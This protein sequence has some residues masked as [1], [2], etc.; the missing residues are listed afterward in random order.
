[1]R[2]TEPVYFEFE[3]CPWFIKLQYSVK[4]PEI[5]EYKDVSHTLPVQWVEKG[6]PKDG[7]VYFNPIFICPGKEDQ[8]CGIKAYNLY[9][10]PGE[11]LFLCRSCHD[12]TYRSAQ[13]TTEREARKFFK[14]VGLL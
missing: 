2:Q 3:S 6:R 12:L 11:D 1:M 4:H 10:P 8:E 14:A 13:N 9:L 5:D 7:Y